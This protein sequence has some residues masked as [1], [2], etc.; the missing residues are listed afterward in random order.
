MFRHEVEMRK[1]NEL[2]IGVLVTMALIILA[3]K[4]TGCGEVA[5]SPSGCGEI[6]PAPGDAGNSTG[7]TGGAASEP[8]WQLVN[9][10]PTS[11]AFH[12]I[13]GTS[14]SD[15]WAAGEK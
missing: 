12:A 7:A 6:V 9:P 1:Q 15:I 8:A 11:H 10:I 2:W 13:G 4:L 5:R 3:G 14:E